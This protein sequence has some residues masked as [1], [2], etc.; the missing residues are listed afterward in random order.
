M[1]EKWSDLI[2]EFVNVTGAKRE[3]AKSLLDVTNGNLEMAIEM[4]FDSCP[5]E[6]QASSSAVQDGSIESTASSSTSDQPK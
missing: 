1:A 6:N 3:R 4:H 5:T 2:A